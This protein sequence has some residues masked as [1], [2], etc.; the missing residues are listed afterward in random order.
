MDILE[1]IE[2]YLDED[3]AS[4][5]AAMGGAGVLYHLAGLNLPYMPQWYLSGWV[6]VGNTWDQPEQAVW[7]DTFVG[8]ALSLLIETPVGPMEAGYGQ[9]SS[10][11][12]NVFLQ[13]G[14]H[15]AL[16]LNH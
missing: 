10:G 4:G 13:A 16:P 14:I 11:S 7:R 3:V 1:Q 5:G 15:F 8:G 9:S 2:N 12:N 6:D